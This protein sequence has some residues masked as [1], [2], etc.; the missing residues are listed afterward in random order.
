MNCC[1]HLWA[2]INLSSPSIS[3]PY[4]LVGLLTRADTEGGE[5]VAW[6]SGPVSGD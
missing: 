2:W 4:H 1:N 5:A 6:P 3:Q